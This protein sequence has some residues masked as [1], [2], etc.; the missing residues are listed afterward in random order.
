MKPVNPLLKQGGR[1]VPGHSGNPQG[2]PIGALN[3]NTLFAQALLDGQAEKLV[4]TAVQKALRGDV[5]ALRLCLD[6]IIVPL[7]ERPVHLAIPA[8]TNPTGI[9]RALQSIFEAI[10]SGVLTPGEA[11]PLATILEAQRRAM[12][13]ADLDQRIVALETAQ[14]KVNSQP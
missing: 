8:A 3:K 2:R 5:A 14:Q 1:F 7:R 6:R 10:T 13:T 9:S 4:Q 11:Q 12:E